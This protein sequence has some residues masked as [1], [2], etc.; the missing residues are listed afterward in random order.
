MN[1]RSLLYSLFFILLWSGYAQAQT[2]KID[3]ELRSRG[4]LRS[5][6]RGPLADTL[7][8]ALVNNLRV[9]LGA[10]YADKNFKAKVTIQDTETYGSTGTNKTGNG[11]GIYEAWGE[12]M[13][14]PEFSGVLG[15][16]I[17]N[18][19]DGRLLSASNWSNTPTAHDALKFKYESAKF[20]A[21]IGGAWN[22]AADV[23]YESVYDKTYQSLFYAWLYKP[24]G[25]FNASAIWINEG[26]QK[27]TAP[28]NVKT[29]IFRNTV[30][31]NVGLNDASI[32]FSFYATG[33]YQF[34]FDR[35]DK[36]LSAYLLAL[37]TQYRFSEM[38]SGTLGVDYF[39]GSKSTISP[40]KDHTFNKLYGANHAFNGSMEYWAA[41]PVQG[42]VDYYIGAD[43][44]AT[45]KLS[46]N[47]T[48]H[49]FSTAE[50]MAGR[51]SKGIGSEID[52]LADYKLSPSFSIQG[53][54]ST[55][56]ANKGT[57]I[58]KKQVGVDTRF[59]QWAYIMI[60]FK[61]TFYSKVDN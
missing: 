38:F 17:L 47:G 36:D 12:Y 3:G 43:V 49:T 42:L 33:Y 46:F 51:D 9:R 4:E 2:I 56:M 58:L 53:G 7:D 25:K 26:F 37:K 23:L 15:R 48:F 10:Y 6:F 20:Q 29:S 1:C 16:Q 31:A 45:P 27:G 14:T 32:P 5:G 34:G 28:E 11:L 22:N 19:D 54:W 61:P 52:L 40:G 41:L 60:T 59:P 30:G 44:K 21:H 13:F 55:Y 39:S 24:L 50:K 8:A 57:D 35:L 18:Y